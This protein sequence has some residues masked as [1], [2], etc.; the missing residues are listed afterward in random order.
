M[1][2]YTPPKRK[3]DQPVEIRP[4]HLTIL[5]IVFLISASTIGSLW[6]NA[7]RPTSEYPTARLMFW[8]RY[9]GMTL[10]LQTGEMEVV[11]GGPLENDNPW[12]KMSPDGKWAARWSSDN[13][14][15]QWS[16][17][18]YEGVDGPNRGFI[19][20]FGGGDMVSW[21]A[22]S[23]WIAFSAYP[24]GTL[25]DPND[26]SQKELY[27]ANIYT[28]EIK[29][30]TDN[31]VMDSGPSFSPDGTKIAYTSS[32][33]GRNYLHIMDLK[34]GETRL[35]TSE[36][37]GYN[38][39]WSPDGQWIAFVT[40]CGSRDPMRATRGALWMIR[41]DGTEAHKIQQRVNFIEP[42]WLS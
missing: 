7:S 24:E 40:K 15:C 18:I 4:H 28:H 17:H 30:L 32:A 21:S 38:P 22:D 33:Y 6:W 36:I 16:L 11:Q 2:F 14:C 41:A 31:D 37:Q 29:Q 10:D 1:V 5:S 27:L 19:T 12:L 3:N 25:H 34:T 8:Q 9:E 26:P 42:R 39:A 23:Q 35:L 13:E 20:R